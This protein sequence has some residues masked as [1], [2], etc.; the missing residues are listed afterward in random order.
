MESGYGKMRD[1]DLIEAMRLLIFLIF[2]FVFT[3]SS[4]QA[5]KEEPILVCTI[6]REIQPDL[7]P[8]TNYL[9]DSLELD[10]AFTDSLPPGRYTV[11]CNFK[12]GADGTLSDICILKDP[13]YGLGD[14]V[15]RVAENYCK[16]ISNHSKSINYQ[17]LP[18]T[19]V[20]ED[21]E[22]DCSIPSREAI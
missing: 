15:L 19:F 3:R 8:F 6:L 17:R 21:E 20:I 7:K 1:R 10:S 18:V 14:F 13:G 22:E 9:R 11:I 12:I 2:L 5:G 16:R 4:A